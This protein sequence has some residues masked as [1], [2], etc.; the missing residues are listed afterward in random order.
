MGSASLNSGLNVSQFQIRMAGL[1]AI[2]WTLYL[3]EAYH[4][5]AHFLVLTGWKRLPRK[6]LVGVKYYF[7][8]DA[9]T[10]A[11]AFL[12]HQNIYF[13]HLGRIQGGQEGDFLVQ[14]RLGQGQVES[15]G[16]GGGHSLCPQL[17]PGKH[18]L[19]VPPAVG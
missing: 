8:T 2:V 4:A 1:T 16:S 18:V 12:L 10:V 9:F 15:S 19:S 3:M 17:S 5:I 14:P 13:L 6:D 7:L 11:V